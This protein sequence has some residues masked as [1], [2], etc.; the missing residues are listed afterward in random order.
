MSVALGSA[1]IGSDLR[2]KGDV[3]SKGSIEVHGLVE[4]T[5]T[6]E[7]LVV[8][9][10]GRVHGI[11]EAGSAEVAGV[12]EGRTKVRNVISIG[13]T[14]KVSGDVRY[15]TIALADGGE[16]V[17]DVRNVPPELG[18]DFHV[19]VRRGRAVVL[20]TADIHAFDPDNTAEELTYNVSSVEQGHVA[21]AS[22]PG[23]AVASFT[24]ADLAAGKVMFVHDGSS[25]GGTSFGVEVVDRAGATSG[26]AQKVT[27]AVV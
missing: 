16:L 6:C 22:T 24:Q 12:L 11:I 25:G 20:T 3:R 18:G 23:R 7:H 19:V 27:V 5:V 10:G 8:H 15:G 2:V 4:G 14:G 21:L 26:G 9:S 1:I 17:A 13:R